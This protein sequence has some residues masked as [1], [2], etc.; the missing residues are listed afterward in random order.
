M[1]VS[2]AWPGS[3]L[4]ECSQLLWLAMLVASSFVLCTQAAGDVVFVSQDGGPCTS[5]T[6]RCL[7][8]ADAL[9]ATNATSISLIM[10]ITLDPS[11]FPSEGLYV[12]RR[13]VNI[14]SLPCVGTRILDFNYIRYKVLMG[15]GVTLQF[16]RVRMVRARLLSDASIDMLLGGYGSAVIL[17]DAEHFRIAGLPPDEVVGLTLSYPRPVRFPGTQQVTQMTPGCTPGAMRDLVY[18]DLAIRI[19]G[20]GS[21]SGGA[22]GYDMNLLNVSRLC[23]ITIP[24]SCMRELTRDQCL[25]EYGAPSN[26]N[27]EIEGAEGPSEQP[28]RPRW[29]SDGVG[30]GVVASVA[31][32]S[33]LGGAT[34]TAAVFLAALACVRR[35]QRLGRRPAASDDASDDASDAKAETPD[36]SVDVEGQPSVD[37]A[38]VVGGSGTSCK[39]PYGMQKVH[40]DQGHGGRAQRVTHMMQFVP[41]SFV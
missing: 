2:K 38:S 31:A 6:G 28:N 13:D 7:N 34:V 15:P 32:G 39:S 41:A 17:K 27:A 11:D 30:A 35:Q 14:S 4:R 8:F 1:G 24:E 25:A 40:V 29:S 26:F 37:G 36:A 3:R 22:F 18:N 33:A 5:P 12:L 23:R 16:E 21:V 10:D 9:M 19:G 20:N